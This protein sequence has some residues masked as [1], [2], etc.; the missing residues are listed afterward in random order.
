MVRRDKEIGGKTYNMLLPSP[1]KAMPLCT[2]VAVLLGPAIGILGQQANG[3]GLAKFSAALQAVDPDKLDKLMMDAVE[4][5]HLCCNGQPVSSQ[6]EFEK[7]FDEH[8]SDTY[9]VCFWVV[10]ECVRD[11]F[12]Q[13][14]AFIPAAK[15]KLAEAMAS[16]SPTAGQ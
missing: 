12:P 13:L 6:H 1:R 8:R 14:D 11:F 9:I 3:D 2:R 16:Q 4:V 10:W 7:H 5:A 15:D